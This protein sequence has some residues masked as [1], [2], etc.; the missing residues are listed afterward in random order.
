MA[1]KL[2][3][4]KKCEGSFKAEKFNADKGMCIRCLEEEPVPAAPVAPRQK[5]ELDALAE[6]DIRQLVMLMFWRE[7][8]RNPEMS[9][10]LTLREL[11]QFNDSMTFLGVT[12]EIVVVRPEGRPAQEA[13][14][15]AK[16]RRAI[17]ARPAE[18]P[19]PYVFIGIV[20]QGTMNG[21]KPIESDEDEA[22]MRDRSM[23]IRKAK[24]RA[25]LLA[26]LLAGMAQSG[27]FSNSEIL[28]AAQTLQFLGQVA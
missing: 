17:A 18:P 14:A 7:R 24:D 13:I 1:I 20:E 3:E 6:G 12:P 4:C 16:G 19:R 8:H 10:Q 23:S 5:D 28:E 25:G 26:S 21:V 9:H 22:K 11:K 2:F 15:A 27:T